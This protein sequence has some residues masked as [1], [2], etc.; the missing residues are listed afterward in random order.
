[1]TKDL[2]LVFCLVFF[3]LQGTETYIDFKKQAFYKDSDMKKFTYLVMA[4]YVSI[5]KVEHHGKWN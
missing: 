3:W 4:I 1:M 2:F 5:S